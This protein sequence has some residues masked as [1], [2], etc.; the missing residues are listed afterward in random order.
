M[1]KISYEEFK[2]ILDLYL[3][4]SKAIEDMFAAYPDDEKEFKEVQRLDEIWKGWKDELLGKHGDLNCE[5]TRKWV[6]RSHALTIVG[7]F[8]YLPEKK[9]VHLLSVLDVEVEGYAGN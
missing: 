9:L 3:T 7:D 2:E 1:Y 6:A 5:E 8:S 4:K